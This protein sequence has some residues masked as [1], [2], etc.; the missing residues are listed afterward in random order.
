LD[1][2]ETI[3]NLHKHIAPINN[4]ENQINVY[5]TIIKYLEIFLKKHMEQPFKDPTLIDEHVTQLNTVI[6]GITTLIDAIPK[7]DEQFQKYV[8]EVSKVLS[9]YNKDD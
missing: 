3:E 1:N 2:K 5:N 4:R 6:E 8:G 9:K 7:T